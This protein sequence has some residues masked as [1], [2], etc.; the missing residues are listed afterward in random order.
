MESIL[1]FLSKVGDLFIIFFFLFFNWRIIALQ[2]C[3]VSALQGSLFK[4]ESNYLQKKR[5]VFALRNLF[6]SSCE[7][8]EGSHWLS[9]IAQTFYVFLD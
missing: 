9:L 5:H 6:F 4:Y 8:L 3:V 2:Y 1:S 7:L